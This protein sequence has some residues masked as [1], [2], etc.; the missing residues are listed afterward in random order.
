MKDLKCCDGDSITLECQIDG[1]PEPNVFW[2]K[3]GEKI[4]NLPDFNIDY[5]EGIARLSINRV[6]SEDEGEYTCIASNNIG[7][8]YSSAC[9][10]VDGK[11]TSF[12]INVIYLIIYTF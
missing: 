10:V 3:D 5:N 1:Q 6:F 7:R 12:M 9:I 8:S 2:E 4:P 11:Y